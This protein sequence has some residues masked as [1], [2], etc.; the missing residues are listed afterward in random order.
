MS[1]KVSHI[2]THSNSHNHHLSTT[3]HTKEVKYLTS[4][5]K[6]VKSHHSYYHYLACS[7]N[8][9]C[10]SHS[11]KIEI[12]YIIMPAVHFIISCYKCNWYQV[13]TSSKADVVW[14]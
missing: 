13:I 5:Y 9:F 2:H 3:T 14:Y 1:L 6:K 7:E 8:T 12:F 11:F 10:E 4:R